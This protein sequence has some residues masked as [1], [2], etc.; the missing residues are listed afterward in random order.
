MSRLSVVILYAAET[1]FIPEYLLPE[2]I[3]TYIDVFL[4]SKFLQ[5]AL[6]YYVYFAHKY[7]N[8]AEKPPCFH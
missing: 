3:I 5:I 8:K 4:N 2:I 7:K 1:V 6:N